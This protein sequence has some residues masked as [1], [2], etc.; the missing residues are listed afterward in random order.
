MVK[1]QFHNKPPLGDMP[2]HAPK[3][4]VKAEFARRLQ[5][6]MVRKGWNQSELA[7]RAAEN[8]TD[9]HF[10]RDNISLYIRGIVMPGPVHLHALSKALSL[11]PD[12]LLPSRGAPSADD[13]VPPL[14][15][16]DAGN[17]KA[18]LRVNMAVEWPVAV[19][20]MKL[21]KDVVG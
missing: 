18:W 2:A 16:R 20:V 21:L 19:E 5:A 17:G 14:D 3:D 10:G 6:A 15:I 7:R 11:K 12:E 13:R 4:A 8:T 9:G 1:K